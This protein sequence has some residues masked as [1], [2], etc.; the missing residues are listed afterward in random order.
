[1]REA[2]IENDQ[3]KVD[4]NGKVVTKLKINWNK[5]TEFRIGPY[6]AKL[7]VVYD[8]GQ[9]DVVLEGSSTFWV[10]P[11][12]IIG[13]IVIG[14]IILFFAVKFLLRWYVG[15]QVSKSRR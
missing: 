8:D 15:R 9:R 11:Y 4:G 10:I 1:M 12:K 7:L 2:V 13:G 14:L 6:E 3:V 5:L